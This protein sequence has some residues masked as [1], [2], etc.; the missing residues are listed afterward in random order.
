MESELFVGLDAHKKTVVATVLDREGNR[1]DQSTLGP[2]DSQLISYLDRLPGR[3]HVVLEAC[4]VWEHYFDAVAS[5]GAEVTLA[6]PYRVRLISEAS[7][8]SDKADSES[9]AELPRLRGIPVAYAPDP[10]IRAL[11]QLVR[12]RWFS[13]REESGIK[14]HIYSILLRKGIPYDDGLLGQ[15]RKREELRSHQLPQVDRGLDALT[16]VLRHSLTENLR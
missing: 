6:H 16:P 7:L 11:R 10:E 15:R 12:D 13:K 14:S 4:S 1:V 9:L 2:L 3:K 5:T 8:K